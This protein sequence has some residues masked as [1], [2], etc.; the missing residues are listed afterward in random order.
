MH[1]KQMRINLQ[2]VFIV[3]VLVPSFIWV[4][5]WAV[6]LVQDVIRFA[7]IQD[8]YADMNC[9]K[10]GL[11]DYS[12][13]NQHEVPQRV[14]VKEEHSWRAALVAQTQE[15][16][17]AEFRDIKSPY[18]FE[19]NWN[20]ESNLRSDARWCV[21]NTDGTARFLG[22]FDEDGNWF[23]STYR[24][25]KCP[26]PALANFVDPVMLVELPNSGVMWNEPVDIVYHKDTHTLTLRGEILDPK[27]LSNCPALRLRSGLA[28]IRQS[29]AP[30]R[31]LDSLLV[32]PEEYSTPL[33]DA[34]RKAVFTPPVPC[35]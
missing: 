27:R 14:G 5:S 9:A 11:K 20:V 15:K 35:D 6:V 24:G 33:T 12:D 17:K 10:F 31:I 23:A 13:R 22:I 16:G 28:M 18:S 25:S 34:E 7:K 30:H 32:D 21:A 2:Q 4:G 26:E 19:L 8:V 3:A 29:S 1:F